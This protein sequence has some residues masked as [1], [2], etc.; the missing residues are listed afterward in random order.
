MQVLAPTQR[1]KELQS[2]VQA[3]PELTMTP[4]ANDQKDNEDE[5]EGDLA[6]PL[7]RSFL[8]FPLP[9]LGTLLQ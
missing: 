4:L 1:P 9:F 7:E 8:R 3:W 2:S 5:E 6:M